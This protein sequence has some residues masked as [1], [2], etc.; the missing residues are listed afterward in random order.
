MN[1]VADD[2]K[3]QVRSGRVTSAADTPDE[4]SLF[5][6]ITYFDGER[7]EVTVTR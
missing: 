3:V 2:F 4:L 7:T 5:D 1:S 6:G